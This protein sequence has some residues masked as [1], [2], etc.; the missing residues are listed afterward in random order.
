MFALLPPPA[1]E[2]LAGRL[3]PLAVAAGETVVREGELGELFYVV[4]RGTLRVSQDGHVLRTLGAG[5]F[6]GEIALLRAVPRTATVTAA[7]ASALGT[8]GRDEFLAAVTG[9]APSREAA[10]AVVDA[11]L[12]VRAPGGVA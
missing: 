12:T 4:E 1:L 6:F 2:G 5:E 7:E 11:R 10:E 3:R 8:L 9:H